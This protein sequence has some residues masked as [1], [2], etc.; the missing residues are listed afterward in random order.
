MRTSDGDVYPVTM[1]NK[2]WMMIDYLVAQNWCTETDLADH[3]KRILGNADPE[4]DVAFQDLFWAAVKHDY[5]LVKAKLD[6]H[7]NENEEDS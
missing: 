1:H 2:F 3:A 7:V 4:I 5:E 6:G